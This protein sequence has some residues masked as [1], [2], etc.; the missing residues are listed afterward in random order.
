MLLLDGKPTKEPSPYKRNPADSSKIHHFEAPKADILGFYPLRRIWE[1]LKPQDYPRRC[2]KT[3]LQEHVNDRCQ[4]V[5]GARGVGHHV[6]IG[7]KTPVTRPRR[8]FS[9][10]TAYG[11]SCWSD[12]DPPRVQPLGLFLVV[13][14]HKF[15]TLGGFRYTWFVKV[16][17]RYR[18]PLIPEVL[19][20]YPNHALLIQSIK[21]VAG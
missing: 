20:H 10:R 21:K 11:T 3:I 7:L 17:T 13:K 16:A 4:A 9:W 2:E 15:H 8:A 18:S 19:L 1:N 6:V 12:L 5:R 14:G